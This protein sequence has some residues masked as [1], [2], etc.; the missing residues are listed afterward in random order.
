MD[1]D[2]IGHQWVVKVLKRHIAQKDIRQAYLFTGPPGV[3][4]R[5]LAI[6]MAQALN[7]SHPPHPGGICGI[8]SNCTQI[9]HITHPD[10]VVVQSEQV[11]GVL[12]VDQIRDIQHYLSL[13]PYQASY[14]VAILLRF[15]EANVSAANALLKTL[16][17]PAP[18]VVLVLTAETSEQLLPTIVS[19]CE[20]LRLSP[21][22]LASV[23]T[24]LMDRWGLLSEEADLLAHLSGGRPGYA[25][26]LHQEPN[27]LDLRR[28]WLDD[29]I[30]LLSADR[31][32]RFAFAEKLSHDKEALLEV[33]HIW[34]SFWRDIL[35]Q[36]ANTNTMITNVDRMV[37]IKQ[38]TQ[39]LDLDTA[40]RMVANLRSASNLINSNANTRLVTEV[41][42]LK[43]PHIQ[44]VPSKG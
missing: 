4:R 20:L 14:R 3:G 21:L 18:K 44:L 15:E 1:W 30:R 8:C 41:L 37:E 40:H 12:K 19:R 29:H 24:G 34:L 39:S 35:L 5:T 17:E 27:R 6:R 7:C 36:A 13:A 26:R 2:L 9:E 23:R 11:G 16:E 25:F 10:L 32:T 31:L 33:L 42:M 22:P 28:Q 38:L 43:L